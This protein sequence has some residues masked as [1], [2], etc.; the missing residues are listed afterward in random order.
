MTTSPFP[1]KIM[2]ALRNPLIQFY[3]CAVALIAMQ[4]QLFLYRLGIPNT[5]VRPYATAFL[6]VAEAALLMLPIVF[7][8]RKCRWMTWCITALLTIFMLA[9]QWYFINYNDTIPISAVFMS[10]NL[11]P[12]VLT[13]AFASVTAADI[14]TVLPP[15]ILYAIYRIWLRDRLRN[16]TAEWK[17]KA[18]ATAF[19]L[20]MTIAAQTG[21]SYSSYQWAIVMQCRPKTFSEF[22]EQCVV[23]RFKVEDCGVYL[24][25]QSA[26]FPAYTI[27]LLNN[28]QPD[29]SLTP[30]L[31]NDIEQY[32]DNTIP[33]YTDN[34]HDVPD[35]RNLITIIVESLNSWVVDYRI[36]GVEVTPVLN[37]LF[38]SDSVITCRT[39]LPQIAHG[40][41][42]D[43]HLM[44]NTGLFPIYQGAT[45]VLYGNESY[46]S[47]AKAL[48]RHNYHA[49]EL[50]PTYGTLWNN[51]N[52]TR[53]FGFDR[54]ED[55]NDISMIYEIS[56]ADGNDR[57]VFQYALSRLADMPQPF[58]AQI[59]TISTHSPYTIPSDFSVPITT[60]GLMLPAE[61]LNYLGKMMYFDTALDEFI[62]GLKKNGL[63]NN[64][65]IVII[66]DHNRLDANIPDGRPTANDSD[67]FIPMVIL[68][69]GIGYHHTKV[70]GQID[71]Y[72]T[73]L[74]IMGANDYYWKGVGRSILRSPTVNAAIATDG[75]VV[76][77]TTSTSLNRDARHMSDLMIRSHY[78]SL[79]NKQK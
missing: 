69:T 52:T 9:N 4:I 74:D 3:L 56:E 8:P 28:I 51:R 42:S 1:S 72:P 41:S 21:L 71:V 13:S 2:R 27:M 76:G 77:D 54:F 36:D 40:M 17:I 11:S 50:A 48:S 62:T 32:I 34:L 24:G 29:I 55:L 43:G 35:C 39:I 46:P 16:Y 61:A 22:W 64:S 37:S 49:Y 14:L 18:S 45:S 7:L 25:L 19:A 79:K 70:M 26:G 53:A 73:L 30:G 60:S 66:S 47:I 10:T 58:Y 57:V 6:R 68:N 65:I 33:T 78:F 15:I 75:H 12:I 5:L 59:V 23:N 44:Y 38:N 31:A 67:T 63:Y 20:I